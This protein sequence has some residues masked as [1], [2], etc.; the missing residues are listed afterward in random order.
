MK[1][2]IQH[3][4]G[5]GAGKRLV[6]DAKDRIRLGRRPDNDVP[7]DPQ[8]DRDVSGYH[9]EIRREADGF[10]LHDVGSANGTF[11][12]GSRVTKLRLAAGHEIT[13]GP[14]GPRVAI[15]FLDES[16]PLPATTP[17]ASP[18]AA[19]APPSP[20]VHPVVLAV[21][22]PVPAAAPAVAPAP[23]PAAP[24]PGQAI[25]S[26]LAPE[27][28][29]GARTVAMM[30]DSALSQAR[31]AD[32]KGGVGKSTVF[33]RS[34]VNQAVTKSTRRFKVMTVILIALLVGSAG[35]FVVLRQ[36]E[37][38]EAVKEQQEIRGEMTRLMDQQRSATSEEKQ[39]LAE[40]LEA[41][42]KKLAERATQATMTGKDI[43]RKN[44]KAIYLV[45][46]ENAAQ[47][48]RG[49]CTAF[50]VRK[51]LLSTN[52]HC[53][54]AHDELKAQ[55]SK[56]YVVLNRD[57]T[58]R[59]DV[60]K[61]VQHPA[62]H[63]PSTTISKDVGLLRVDQD[64]ADLVDLADVKELKDLEPGDIMYTYG[65]PGRL[66]NV[67]SPDAT[68]VQGVVGRVT[69]LDGQLGSF[70]ENLLIQHSAF[71]SG[72]TSG[73]PIF[74]QNGKVIA[75]NAGGYVEPGSMQVMDPMTGKA[76]QL[77]VG[78]QLAGYNFG[79]R[80]DVLQGLVADQGE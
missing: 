17:A 79:I 40:K 45:V 75:V 73:S 11:V 43:V 2:E 68:L 18:A 74:G 47:G 76:G 66:A 54:V 15:R 49:F 38:K 53:V 50:A 29:V 13:L 61:A 62:Y 48:A 78:K 65:F 24:S 32:S 12:G 8:I 59:Y 77:I 20:A 3:L 80:I 1:I 64:L 69:K 46:A 22:A 52:S 41:L 16:A 70:E 23:T 31:G 7:F 63:K 6:L 58:K 34:M 19:P 27:Q 67:A 14:S 5:A 55:G 36:L 26:S 71:T 28:K 60:V 35:G 25:V 39:K 51:H 30:I 33:L 42:N 9:A 44:M 21:P 10:Y 4:T 72:G 56:I 37:K 57:T